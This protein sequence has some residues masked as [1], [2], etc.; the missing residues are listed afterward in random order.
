MRKNITKSLLIMTSILGFCSCGSEIESGKDSVNRFT[1][2]DPSYSG[3]TFENTLTETPKNNH[4]VN[5]EFITGGGV[6]A[7]DINNDGLPDIF[8]TGNQVNDRLYINKGE[9][10]F[11]DITDDAGLDDVDSWSTGVSF[12]DIN[13]DGYQ[14][15]YICKNV[16]ENTA[17]SANLLYI[18]NGDETF[19]ESAKEYGL[20]D[21]GFSVQAT[22]LDFDKDGLIDMYLV[23]QPPSIGGRNGGEIDPNKYSSLL[24]SDKLYK[25]MGKEGFVD[26]SDYA[27]MRNFAYGLSAT[28]GDINNDGWPDIYVANDFNLPDHMYLNNADGTFRDVV[29]QSF[30]H[31]S[32]FSM[33][34][35]MADYDNDGNLDLMVVDMVAEDHKRIKTYMGS[36]KPADFWATVNKG[37]HYQYMFN[38]LQRNNGNATFGDLAQLGGVSSTDWSWGP[39][40]ADFDNDGLKDIFVTNGVKRNMRH[41]DI[42]G[43]YDRVLDSLEA[44][45]KA[46][47]KE[48]NDLIDIMKFV[49]MAPID[50]LTNYAYKNNGDLTFTKK[51][52]DWGFDLATLSNGAAYADFDL[53]G[54]LDLI[55]NNI[56]EEAFLYRNNTSDKSGSNYIRLSL[57]TEKS[58]TM[59]GS[60]IYIYRDSSI[61]QM[62]EST[63][64]R[65]Y[66]SKSED[67]IHFG[68]GEIDVVEKVKVVWP[69]LSVTILENVK[70]NQLLEVR[71]KNTI[72]NPKTVKQKK[73]FKG[74]TR[75][76]GIS[77][78]HKENNFDDY[79]KQILLPHKL[80]QFGP[81]LAVGDIN[82]DNLEDFYVGGSAGNPGAMFI[83]TSDGQFV[84]KKN[85][86]W[87]LDKASEDMDSELFDVDNDGDLDLFVVS[88][89]NEFEPD[90]IELKD[91]IY[92]NDGKGNF[93]KDTNILDAYLI[94]GSVVRKADFDKDG[95]VDL[96]IGGRL[97]PGTYPF[98]ASSILLENINGKLINVTE[99]KAPEL[100][101]LGLV[102]SGTWGDINGD[103]LLDLTIVGEWMPVTIFV[104]NEKGEFS[105]QE[106]NGLENTE[107]WYYSIENA[108]MD[109]DGDLD[110]I[111]GNL[112]LN[113]KYKA[114]EEEPFQ[115]HCADFDQNGSL[116]IVLSY[117]E[118]GEVFPVRGRSCSAQQI[119]E[120]GEKFSTFESFGDSNLRGIYGSSLDSSLHL[121]AKT[122]ASFYIENI[123]GS[124]FKL[125]K[126]PQLAQVSSVNNIIVKDFNTDGFKDILISGNLYPAEIET[127]RNDASIGLL[128][129]GDGKG[130]FTARS[131][132]ESGFF[133]PH[134]AKDM[135][136]IK[137]GTKEIVLVGNNNYFL[138]A[139]E[140]TPPNIND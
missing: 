111:V 45:A 37:W 19:T 86:D 31:I 138:Q 77:F 99:K 66:M 61:W 12:V 131:L 16:H 123:N 24:Y 137:V 22:F 7:G 48:L 110:L 102:T 8:L 73:M 127:P 60:R 10:I 124:S 40:I 41:S 88:G 4:L 122:F 15:I 71:Q 135:K 115:V 56:D 126:L 128:L 14:D 67:V 98:A 125:H 30:K 133:A 2:I 35:D 132:K 32:N 63:N 25:N 74:V 9:L 90:D 119:P 65:G 105:K 33:G 38:T 117:Y 72:D 94:S 44:V 49:E 53:D 28:V 55:I 139:I 79:A 83:Q 118:H 68:L 39:L 97:V 93:K 106:I 18:N 134:D 23:N 96:F 34:S 57:L 52:T 136:I 54:D 69:D 21:K 104:Q 50:K 120:I 130:K 20:A 17:E 113:Y 103:N 42:D 108:D 76:L 116:D 129:D 82:G 140:Y 6:A 100:H 13:A 36:M 80:S 46:E 87:N 121:E 59:H 112:G 75:D 95:D 27:G 29:N 26:F 78:V 81:Q 84:E 47:E 101:K 51:N 89:G 5:D 64:V 92:I 114:S 43:I 3:I 109:N 91:R 107:G 70:A 85:G 1:L 11:E 62:V 58:A